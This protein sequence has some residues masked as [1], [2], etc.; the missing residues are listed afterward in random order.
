MRTNFAGAYKAT[1]TMSV[2]SSAPSEVLGGGAGACLPRKVDHTYLACSFLIGSA[3]EQLSPLNNRSSCDFR[4][5]MH[6]MYSA[7]FRI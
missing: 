4:M 3:K 2:F 5:M 1:I 7:V 6:F